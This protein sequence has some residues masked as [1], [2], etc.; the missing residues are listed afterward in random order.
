MSSG[1]A[2]Y[3]FGIDQ[4]V[5]DLEGAAGVVALADVTQL[6]IVDPVMERLGLRTA[7][8][9]DFDGDGYPDAAMGAY[10][11][12]GPGGFNSGGVRLLFGAPP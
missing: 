5:V 10:A 7:V 4:A 12:N 1:H 3:D 6:S 9:T 8:G 2:P 11:I